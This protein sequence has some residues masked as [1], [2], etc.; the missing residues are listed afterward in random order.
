MFPRL[1]LTRTE[2][3]RASAEQALNSYSERISGQIA[4]KNRRLSA[5]R[6]CQAVAVTVPA[7]PQKYSSTDIIV[8]Q[9]VLD[10]W[11]AQNRFDPVRWNAEAAI[12]VYD[13]PL[14]NRLLQL[15]DLQALDFG[16]PGSYHSVAATDGRVV[17]AGDFGIGAPVAAVIAE[18]L[19][20]SGVTQILSIGTAGGIQTDLT[21]G[22]IISIHG[23]IRD[24][25]TSHHYLPA[26]AVVR[27]DPKLTARLEASL[28]DALGRRGS[29][30]TTDAPFRETIEELRFHRDAGV[31][32]V[33]M[34]A[35][36]LMAV[37]ELRG[38]AFASSVCISDVLSEQGW[39]ALFSEASVREA[40]HTMYSAAVATLM[41]PR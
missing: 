26:D 39:K 9:A 21:P 19:I 3:P 13:R 5:R 34:E 15:D 22:Q 12:L 2:S 17:L 27:P 41:E 25:G 23:A 16:A 28:G 30:W 10:D 40:L 29:V 20:A 35:A 38:A 8:A 18:T 31:L 11:T 36:A 24:D 1:D 7:V 6:T 37:C 4:H 32:A 33:E 14:H